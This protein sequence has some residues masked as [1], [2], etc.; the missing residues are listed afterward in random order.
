HVFPSSSGAATAL[1][2]TSYNESGC[3]GFIYDPHIAPALYFLLFPI[4]LLLN[5]VAAWVFLHLKSEST[6]IVYL[7]NLVA[8]DIVMTVLV[9][10]KAASDLPGASYVL[11]TLSCRYF[12]TMFY[13]TLYTCITLLGLISLDRFFKIMMPHS[14]VFSN[15]TF[16]K[17]V[18]GSV[19]V[20]LF[21]GSALP[22]I[23]LSNKSLA[24]M[25]EIS[26]CM[27]LKGPA[28][29]E[30][31]EMTV[32]SLNVLFWLISVVIAVCYICI[33]NKVIQSFRN[34]GSN[35]NQ[36]KQKIKLRVFLVLIVFFVSFGPYHIIRIPYTFQQVNYSSTTSCSYLLGGFAKD[37]SLW[38]A[39]TNICMNPLLYVFLCREFQEALKSMMN[40]LSVSF[41][42]ASAEKAGSSVPKTRF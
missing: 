39:T 15:L 26:T 31:H 41:C 23:I 20:I 34:S 36:G 33:T 4:A 14:K 18:S 8:A 21:G 3:E 12:S 10:I 38:F 1:N 2:E 29:L 9:P 13:S 11:F 16:S 17:V 24:N 32:I 6:F 19:W 30:A 40:S 37:L 27:K 25:T 5:S 28:G 7:K 42:G 35:N 22:N